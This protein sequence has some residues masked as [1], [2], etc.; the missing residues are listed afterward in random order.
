MEL[1]ECRSEESI[2]LQESVTTAED[3]QN[4]SAQDKTPKNI[5]S[6]SGKR[7]RKTN[8]P[9]SSPNTYEGEL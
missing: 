2:G 7:K 5:S 8:S 9:P 1:E 6:P 3:V 4:G